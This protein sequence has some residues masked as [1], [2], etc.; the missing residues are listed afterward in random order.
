VFINDIHF[1]NDLLL[2]K[3]VGFCHLYAASLAYF[4]SL[5]TKNMCECIHPSFR[6][7]NHLNFC[8]CIPGINGVRFMH[9]TASNR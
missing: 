8:L 9:S 3:C 6:Q 5:N 1:L 2:L 4:V 7:T